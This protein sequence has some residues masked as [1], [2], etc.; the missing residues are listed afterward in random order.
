MTLEKKELLQIVGGIN[1]N[2]SFISA[3]SRGINS[4]LDLG[5]SI[6]TAI[7]RISSNSVCPIS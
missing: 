7:R 1:I 3:I 4:I 6:G 2:A 5:R